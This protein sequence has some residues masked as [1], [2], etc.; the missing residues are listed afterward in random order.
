LSCGNQGGK[1]QNKRKASAVFK[2]RAGK[3]KRESEKCSKERKK[4][5]ERKE[6]GVHFKHRNGMGREAR[7]G[8]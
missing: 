8:H 7:R 1:M 6:K 2:W 3:K 4:R 5:T